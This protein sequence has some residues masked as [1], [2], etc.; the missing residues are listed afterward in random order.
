MKRKIREIMNESYKEELL[1]LEPVDVDTD[2]IKRRTF[3]KL[4]MESKHAAVNRKSGLV[5]LSVTTPVQRNKRRKPLRVMALAA[6]LVVMMSAAVYAASTIYYNMTKQ[7]ID[8]FSPGTSVQTPVN[9]SIYY[10]EI[11]GD[12]QQYNATV[13]EEIRLS[14]ET[15]T[16]DSIS[17]DDNFM[18]LFFTIVYDAPIDLDENGDVYSPAYSKLQNY[19]PSVFTLVNGAFLNSGHFDS[20]EYDP[21]MADEK[22]IKLMVRSIIPDTLPDVFELGVYAADYQQEFDFHN[23][24]RAEEKIQLTV[25]MRATKPQTKFVEPAVYAFSTKEG[26]KYLDLTKLS[27]SPFGAVMTTRS[28]FI[29]AEGNAVDQKK[30]NEMC[31]EIDGRP[32][33]YEEATYLSMRDFYITDDKG[34][35]VNLS[36]YSSTG[37][38]LD[39]YSMEL[40][41]I[42]SDAQSITLTPYHVNWEE[43]D[44]ASEPLEISIQDVNT[45][46][47][48]SNLGGYT[49]ESYSIVG[50]R[51]S[52]VL[53][54]YGKTD[55]LTGGLYFADNDAIPLAENNRSGLINERI[56]R[57]TGTITYSVD[58]YAAT[59]ADLEQADILLRVHYDYDCV[60]D[61]AAA[62]TLPLVPS[63][64]AK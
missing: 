24:A 40:I 22:T 32:E 46:I 7:E 30:I 58:Y 25:D 42:A 48:I 26:K 53:K 55:Y 37:G 57:K 23:P 19:I 4:Q 45:K 62:I 28:H 13:G 20:R 44:T 43:Q 60:L 52:V 11:A 12:I 33:V 34:N 27:V 49:L 63:R 15:L 35:V 3:Q 39:Y 1:N 36:S 38:Y 8:Y 16:L 59:Q 18:N 31:I 41:G 64:S 47:P 10:E 51:V 5:Y 54:P 2:E 56:D 21:Y 50:S 9:S 14:R 61:E 17:V 29:D 6:A